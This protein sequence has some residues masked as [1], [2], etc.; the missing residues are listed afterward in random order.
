MIRT[1][2]DPAKLYKYLRAELDEYL[3]PEE[4]KLNATDPEVLVAKFE[5]AHISLIKCV[6]A[7]NRGGCQRYFTCADRYDSLK[8]ALKETHK[9]SDLLA[10]CCKRLGV[11]IGATPADYLA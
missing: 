6:R 4:A 7:G 10:A 3:L 11:S 2:A 5:K 9:G 8:L 1:T